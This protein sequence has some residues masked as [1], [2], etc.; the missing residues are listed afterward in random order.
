MIYMICIIYM[1]YWIYVLYRIYTKYD[2]DRELSEMGKSPT[3][4]VL[5]Q[6]VLQ[7]VGAVLKRLRRATRSIWAKPR[8]AA[9]GSGSRHWAS[10]NLYSDIGGQSALVA[11]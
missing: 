1:L 4:I 5:Q 3:R 7:N 9:E 10:Y 6:F 2:L 8:C 11:C